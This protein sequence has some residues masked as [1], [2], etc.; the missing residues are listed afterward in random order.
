MCYLFVCLEVS[1]LCASIHHV[2]LHMYCM[3][4]PELDGLCAEFVEFI[5]NW[6]L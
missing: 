1:N 5:P 2:V 3:I 4:S 6:S